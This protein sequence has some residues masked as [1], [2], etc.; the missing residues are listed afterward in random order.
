MR[1]RSKYKPKPVITNPL[2]LLQPAKREQ[3]QKLL[4][5]ALSALESITQCREPS[6]EDWRDLSDIVNVVEVAADRGNLKHEEV[7]PSVNAAIEAMC[8]AH[9]RFNA[10]KPMRMSGAGINALRALI[11]VYAELL[12]GLTGFEMELLLSQTRALVR[13]LQTKGHGKVIVL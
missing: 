3:Q 13:R 2:V 9:D 5:R 8:E 11:Q 4:M 1:K 7:M 10:G 12:N 6:V